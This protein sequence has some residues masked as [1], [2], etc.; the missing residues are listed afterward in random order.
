MT[1]R[2]NRSA[3]DDNRNIIEF[4]D[5]SPKNPLDS[6]G[7]CT[8]DNMELYG[9]MASKGHNRIMIDGIL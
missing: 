9:R 2:M 3:A 8:D 5:K 1:R 6:P 4:Y 7:F